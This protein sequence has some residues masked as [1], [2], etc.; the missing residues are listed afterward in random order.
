MIRRIGIINTPMH[1]SPK[2]F[3]HPLICATILKNITKD[4]GEL[5]QMTDCKNATEG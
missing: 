3:T 5:V 4:S 2:P 1:L